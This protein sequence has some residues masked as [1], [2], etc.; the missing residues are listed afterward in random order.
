MKETTLSKITASVGRHS[1]IRSCS[2]QDELKQRR[3]PRSSICYNLLR[4]YPGALVSVLYVVR[5]FYLPVRAP[6]FGRFVS[7]IKS[8]RRKDDASATRAHAKP[9]TCLPPVA[10]AQVKKAIDPATRNPCPA[11]AARNE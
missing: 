10:T 7:M 4:A 1:P 5:E 3:A 6:G 9:Q 8:A 11:I 2:L